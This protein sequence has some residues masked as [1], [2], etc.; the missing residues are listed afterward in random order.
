MPAKAE[1][2]TFRQEV[3]ADPDVR[4]MRY[5]HREFTGDCDACLVGRCMQAVLVMW[6]GNKVVVHEPER[7]FV[8]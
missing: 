1:Y 7:A 2:R 6:N 5:T 3:E 8:H 4:S